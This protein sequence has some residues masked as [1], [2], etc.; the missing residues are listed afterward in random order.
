[1]KNSYTN[2]KSES[3]SW[4]KKKTIYILDRR[5]TEGGGEGREK[6]AEKRA[7]EEATPRRAHPRS[8]EFHSSPLDLGAATRDREERS[9]RP[10]AADPS[11]SVLSV[12]ARAWCRR[13]RAWA[14]SS[15]AAAAAAAQAQP[16]AAA[17]SSATSAR[18]RTSPPAGSRAPSA[19]RAPRP[20]RGSP[21]SSRWKFL[22][23][24]HCVFMLYI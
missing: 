21:S 16:W 17:R 22:V 15:T 12:R 14:S 23:T 4:E 11:A 6:R 19:R 8:F 2:S 13:R 3:G 10:A 24:L 7:E 9:H 1:M 5:A 20:S 18:R